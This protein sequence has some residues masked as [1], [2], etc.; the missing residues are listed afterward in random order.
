MDVKA[1]I[2]MLIWVALGGRG[3]L[4]GAVVGALLV[5]LLYSLF[6]SWMPDAWPYIL[7]LL[8]VVTVLYFQKGILGWLGDLFQG[9]KEKKL[10]KQKA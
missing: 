5:S 1:S 8:Y 6:T 4:K 3:S 10:F 9:L 7:G 2:E